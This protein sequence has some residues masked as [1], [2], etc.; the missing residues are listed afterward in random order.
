MRQG[1]SAAIFSALL[2]IAFAS[3]GR[4][5]GGG[6]W[7]T[8]APMPVKRQELA[9]ALLDGKVYVLGGYDEMRRSTATVEVYNP[10][11]D[12]WAFAHSLPFEVNHN[13][14][15]VAAGRLYSFGAGVGQMFVYNTN[16]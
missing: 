2:W 11:T 16:G 12:S 3:T 4:T 7:E 13:A 9:T 15:A 14:A 8:R 6:T 10:A 1:F 5:Q